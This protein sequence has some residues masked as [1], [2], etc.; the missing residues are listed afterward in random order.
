MS[1]F[2]LTEEEIRQAISTAEAV[3]AIEA[4]FAALAYG[5]V[6]LPEVINFTLPSPHSSE[7]PQGE[8]HVKGAHISGALHFVIKV[9]NSFPPNRDLGIPINSGLMLAFD[10]ITGVLDA[11]LFDNGYLTDLRTGAAG[12]VAA[13]Y[14]ASPT[15]R[16][17]AFIGAGNQA[18]FQFR[19]IAA[20]RD[21][22]LVSVWSRNP[23]NAD[24]FARE[25]V[26]DRG[27]DARVAKTVEEAVRNSNLVI[28]TTPSRQALV[29]ANWIQPGTTVIA[30]G[31]D[32]PDKQELDP[33]LLAGADVVVA[34]RLNQCTLFGEIHHAL[35]AGL[36]T[37]EDITGELGDVIVGR[38]AGRTAEEQVIV[39]DLTGVGVQ[40]AAIASLVLEKA[41]LSGLGWEQSEG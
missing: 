17:A 41:R 6:S 37:I 28:T 25:V 14:L 18:R 12:A 8:S 30:V 26:D 11:I 15:I 29:S 20:V 23:A 33:S 36:L 34:D 22:P 27:C 32:T 40:D 13:R 10:A 24:N 7:T 1:T 31:S 5:K 21:I 16:Q 19:A 3:D 4:A 2:F 9:A 35:T 39:C 38:V